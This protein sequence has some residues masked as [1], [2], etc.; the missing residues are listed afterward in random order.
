MVAGSAEVLVWRAGWVTGG[1][2][3]LQVGL[4]ADPA[5][6]TQI[7]R[8]F[9][10]L[11]LSDGE[12]LR[13]WDLEV[14]SEPF[15]VACEDVDTALSRLTDQA[16]QHRW[17]VVV[18]VTELPLRA[19]DGG[20]LLIATD[21]EHRA[22]VLSLP[23]L[24]GLR[25]H[26]RSRHALRELI[27]G[28]SN[29]TSESGRVRRGP[30]R[31]RVLGHRPV[32]P[33]LGPRSRASAVAPAWSTAH[34]ASSSRPTPPISMAGRRALKHDCE[35]YTGLVIRGWTVVRFAWEHGMHEQDYVC[36]T[37]LAAAGRPSRRAVLPPTLLWSA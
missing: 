16:H 14:V 6:P 35:R 15:T 28:M 20:Y 27:S 26:K 10:D 21:P 3:P 34:A 12:D 24:G 8:R 36:D 1:V 4:V 13:E 19:G 25:T 7:A 31:L 9:G 17:D 33:L 32:R 22:A 18:G 2:K 29:P 11:H 30:G 5:K 37:L 23:A